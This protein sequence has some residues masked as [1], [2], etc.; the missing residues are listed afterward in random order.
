MTATALK[1]AIRRLRDAPGFSLAVIATLG[2]AIGAT[3]AVWTVIDAVLI[4]PL[5]YGEPD[6]LMSIAHSVRLTGAS[7][8]DQ[9]DAT[10]L[11]YRRHNSS[12]SAIGAYRSTSV[13]L[14]AGAGSGASGAATPERVLAARVS[15]S[16][17]DLLGVAPMSGRPFLESDDQPGA[18]PVLLL[19]ERLWRRKYAADESIVGRTVDIDG[20][21]HTVAGIMPARFRFP[22]GDTS[23]WVPLRLDPAK[24]DSASFDYQAI[25]R[26]RPGVTADA[27]AADLH[28]ALPRVPDEFP[29]RLTKPSIELIQM[30]PIV[31]PLRDL[32]VGDI[33]RLLW[34][35]FGVAAFVLAAACANVANLFLVRGDGRQRE[36]AVRRALGARPRDL[37]VNLVSEGV[38]L[39]AAGG[40]LGIVVAVAGLRALRTL[41]H[42]GLFARLPDVSID[43]SVLLTAAATTIVAALVVSG[44]PAWRCTRAAVSTILAQSNRSATAGR[45]RQRARAAL[46][47]AQVALA[48]VLLAGAGLMTRTFLRLSAVQPGFEPSGVIAFRVAVPQAKYPTSADA[49]RFFIAAVT[50]ISALPDVAAAGLV[51]RLPLDATGEADTAAFVEDR[52]RAPNTMPDIHDVAYITPGYFA[53]MGVPLLAGRTLGAPDPDREP[54]EVVVSRGF[55]ERYWKDEPAI[56]KR[57][58]ILINGPWFTV[59]GVAGPVR[60]TALEQPPDETI[61]ASIVTAAADRRWAPRD[62]AFVVRSSN[63]ASRVVAASRDILRRHDAGVPIYAVR[64]MRDVL[65]AASAR[66]SF[67]FL[68]LVTASGVALLLGAVGIYGVMSYAISLRTR[69]IGLRLALGAPPRA[70]CAMISRQALVVL[71]IGITAGLGVAA[72]VTRVLESLLYEV[73]PTDPV[74]FVGAALLLGAIGFV[75]SWIPA[76]R[77]AQI[78]PLIAMRIE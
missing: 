38:V 21:A 2:L 49:A 63:D 41:A 32:V 3:T 15:P 59:V 69:E 56:G 42:D 22:T 18:P 72:A 51:S 23:V 54:H 46:V 11:F 36:L 52:P 10:Y 45:E 16:L 24:T 8:V 43:S 67:T 74:T 12:F 65:S 14:G 75:A 6:R 7:Q 64:S 9:S 73:S 62:L 1:H 78:D 53:A 60:G 44:L 35:V 19:A 40:T 30:R 34:V 37:V 20:V 28:A 70:V 48:L 29:G 17:I 27:A 47:A 77:A 71:A 50:E 13:N 31:R 25:G 39:T 66:T 57:V 68:L 33:S 55:A 5:P 76:R 61:Y 4:R 58:R 26:L